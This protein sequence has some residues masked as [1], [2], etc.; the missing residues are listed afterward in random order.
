MSAPQQARIVSN[1]E[2]SPLS[3]ED[4]RAVV[5]RIECPNFL[6]YV[7]AF[8]AF[9]ELRRLARKSGGL[10][11]IA[12]LRRRPRVLIIVSYWESPVAIMRFNNLIAHITTVNW[13][14][15]SGA[16]VWSARL[17]IEGTAFM[18]RTAVWRANGI[19]GIRP[20]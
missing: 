6:L 3:L 15:G 16:R 1:A 17:R 9:V 4:F 12:L 5:T 19:H 10:V 2:P 14:Y 7:R 13:L 18:S 8:L 20:S 11:D